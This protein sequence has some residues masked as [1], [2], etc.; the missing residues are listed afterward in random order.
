MTQT[1]GPNPDSLIACICDLRPCALIGSLGVQL[2][3][4]NTFEKVFSVIW[5]YIQ[6]G[7][8]LLPGILPL[9]VA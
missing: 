4:Q 8:P 1:R 6:C 7:L 9:T 3:P 5:E 2:R